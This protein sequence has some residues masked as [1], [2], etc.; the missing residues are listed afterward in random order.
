ME[1]HGHAKVLLINSP[2]GFPSMQSAISS[3]CS[4]VT[5]IGHRQQFCI[6][7]SRNTNLAVVSTV[8]M[9]CT[10]K[11]ALICE[12]FLIPLRRTFVRAS[13]QSYHFNCKLT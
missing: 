8:S 10:F 3:S 13:S 11:C 9:F 4:F 5:F 2:T 6:S 12:K 1:G 7:S